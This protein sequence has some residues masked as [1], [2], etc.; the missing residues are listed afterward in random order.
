M[1]EDDPV[2]LDIRL[3]GQ[4]QRY[5]VWPT[6]GKQTIAEHCWQILRIYCIVIDKIDPHM[7][8]HA[9]F[10]D[11]GEMFTGDTPYPIKS[12]NHELKKQL[13]YFEE[14]SRLSQLEYWSAF[15]QVYL[16]EEDKLLFK[17]I[18]LIE[19]AEF[20]MDQMCL[21]NSHAFII[22]D[23]C[24]RRVY[25]DGIDSRLLRYVTSRLNTFHKQYKIMTSESMGDWWYVEGWHKRLTQKFKLEEE[26]HVRSE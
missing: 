18:E 15:R 24:L 17:Q 10:H 7:V 6:I 3:S 14:R 11:I 26:P 22:A 4:I 2:R 1:A 23:R 25:Q 20:G 16:S 21:G 5:H 19:M 13:D 9:M 8:M 12:E